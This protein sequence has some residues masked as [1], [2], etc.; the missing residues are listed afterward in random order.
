MPN[1]GAWA[2]MFKVVQSTNGVNGTATIDTGFSGFVPAPAKG[3]QYRIKAD[4]SYIDGK[5]ATVQLT[6]IVSTAV[7]PVP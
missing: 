3:D 4:G 6:G 2:D 7:T 5:G 1:G